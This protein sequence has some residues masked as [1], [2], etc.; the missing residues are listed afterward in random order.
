LIEIEPLFSDDNH[1][2]NIKC[3]AICE[4]FLASSSTDESVRI[5]HIKSK[6]EIGSLIKINGIFDLYIS[7]SGVG[8]SFFPG[9]CLALSIGDDKQ[10]KLWDLHQMKLTSTGKLT[11]SPKI[12]HVSPRM[13]CYAIVFE[14]CLKTFNI[15]VIFQLKLSRQ[16]NRKQ[17]PRPIL[18]LE[19]RLIFS[20]ESKTITVYQMKP[21]ICKY[22]SW[23]IE[24]NRTR[25][26]KVFNI[27]GFGEVIL[28][29]HSEGIVV[30]WD[31]RQLVL[32]IFY[33]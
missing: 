2:G 30:I 13:D 15:R 12:V 10:L 20:G 31:A 7:C 22:M 3:L 18:F 26:L 29:I 16:T 24:Y 32:I 14:R 23:N 27:N 1:T 19:N 11:D 33:N 21:S 4:K 6:K 25:D 17:L 9:S 28:T 5:T 8:L